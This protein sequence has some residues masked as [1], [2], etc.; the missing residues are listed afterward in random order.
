MSYCHYLKANHL[1]E[2]SSFIDFLWNLAPEGRTFAKEFY[3]AEGICM[4][5][6]MSI[7]GKNLGGWAM[8]SYSVTNQ[9][10]LCQAFDNYWKYTG[11]TEFLEQKAYPYLKETAQCVMRWLVKGED[12]KLRLPVSSSPE[13]HDNTID[14]WLTPNSNY[15]LSLMFYLFRTLS[16]MSRVLENGEFQEW[17]DI[18][19][20]LPGLAVNE[21]HVLL[22]SPDEAL[23][24]SHR[25]HAHMMAVYPLN[26][27]DPYSEGH[28]GKIINASVADLERLGSGFWVG[29]SFTWMAEFYARQGN[30]E[31][32]AYQ[33]K[34][35]QECFCSKNGFHLNGDYKKR[36]VSW[37]H[38]RP[39][40][41][42]ANMC[43]ADA[44]QEMLL[45]TF[46][47][48]IRV[49][50]AIPEEWAE[51]GASFTQFRGE[52]GVLVSSEVKGGKLR[53]I[54]LEAE[55]EGEFR[56]QNRYVSDRLFI[57]TEE[58]RKVIT[59]GPDEIFS[60]RLNKHEK[61]RIVPEDVIA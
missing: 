12:G 33:L 50:P 44:L 2:G 16:H 60:V 31:G 59:C 46:N 23:N 57:E 36:G 6:V 42:E 19:D 26:L 34:I 20:A 53:Y 47:G 22:L 32:A 58:S 40:T 37:F 9:I 52:G 45:Q 25:H 29:Y 61:C 1:E 7:N 28:D 11:D 41:L 14:A 30:G 4:P 38:Y 27:L 10:W 17:D 55:K 5:S 39:F 21:Q 3:D 18:L 54:L 51:K 56:L 15:D 24:E 43:A 8:Y 49:F 13:I 35:F 48:V